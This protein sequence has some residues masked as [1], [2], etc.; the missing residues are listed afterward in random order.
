M[1]P[2]KL[3]NSVLYLPCLMVQV[4]LNNV[5]EELCVT[6]VMILNIDDHV[7]SLPRSQVF[8]RENKT[9]LIVIPVEPLARTTES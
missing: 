5:I 2:K 4:S 6:V 8:P 7:C 3:T 9:E 1:F